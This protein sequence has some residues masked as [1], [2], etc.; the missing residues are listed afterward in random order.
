MKVH[1]WISAALISMLCTSVAFAA[2]VPPITLEPLPEGRVFLAAAATDQY[3]YVLGGASDAAGTVPQAD[4]WRYNPISDTWATLAPMPVPTYQH[5]MV[6]LGEK[7]F[8]PGNGAEAT[9]YV[10]DIATDSWDTIAA[11]GG[12][13]ARS[14]Y[15]AIAHEGRI[16]VLGG[17]ITDTD[18][19]TNEVWSLDPTTGVWQPLP[20]ISTARMSAAAGSIGGEV[21]VTGGV[22]FPGFA[23]V[24]STEIFDGSQW[25][26]GPSVP[27][28]GGAYTRWS[29]MG[30]ATTHDSLW[31]LGGR[32]DAGWDV[33]DH[34]GRLQHSAS[35]WTWSFP[36]DLPILQQ[37]RVYLAAASRGEHGIHVLGG[38]DGA[39]STVYA[40]HEFVEL[41][42]ALD[43]IFADGFE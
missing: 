21:V 26:P 32:R 7:L 8:V 15:V 29:Y 16:L 33:L 41:D 43:V 6:M 1:M 10:Y 37:P 9:T 11:N 38:R 25:T 30:H 39:G 36:P 40:T 28:G 2:V 18:V 42:D 20:P 12:Y 4:L 3:V 13:T 5:D 35:G 31:L 23:P 22:G 27:D 17:V 34:V 24:M 19:A 14:Q